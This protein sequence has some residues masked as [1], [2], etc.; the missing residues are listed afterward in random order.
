MNQ[1]SQCF[2]GSL[3]TSEVLTSLA[4]RAMN[5]FHVDSIRQ[6]ICAWNVYLGC[7]W[8]RGTWRPWPCPSLAA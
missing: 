7:R 3:G 6:V 4:P 1:S 8:G 2:R 5:I